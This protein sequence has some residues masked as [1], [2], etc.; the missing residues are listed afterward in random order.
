MRRLKTKAEALVSYPGDLSSGYGVTNHFGVDFT[1]V[2]SCVL[3]N[4]QLY[5]VHVLA[6]H[7]HKICHNHVTMMFSYNSLR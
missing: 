1:L 6:K 7:F 2:V 3:I 5:L 4:H